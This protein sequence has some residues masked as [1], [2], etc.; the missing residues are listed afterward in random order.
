MHCSFVVSRFG[1]HFANLIFLRGHKG[2]GFHNASWNYQAEW[3]YQQLNE[4][5]LRDLHVSNSDKCEMNVC[6]SV[7]P[8]E[9][10]ALS[11]LH[12][13]YWM[14]PSQKC[15]SAFGSLERNRITIVF[16]NEASIFS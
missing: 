7:L 14:L 15:A 12:A 10:K 2:N 16:N 1:P 8:L 4:G 6:L 13:G 3:A 9:G 5:L 11:Q